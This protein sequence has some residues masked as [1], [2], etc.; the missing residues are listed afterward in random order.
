MQIIVAMFTEYRKKNL[1][2]ECVGQDHAN[3]AS[4]F[5]VKSTILSRSPAKG[6]SLDN[7]VFIL[8]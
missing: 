8:V 2:N 3:L 7:Y 6:N 1:R 4:T 5:N